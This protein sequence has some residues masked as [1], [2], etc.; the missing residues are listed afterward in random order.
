MTTVVFASFLSSVGIFSKSRYCQIN[1]CIKTITSGLYDEAYILD[2]Y[3]SVLSS[4]TVRLLQPSL[5]ID[6][7]T[8]LHPDI[9]FKSEWHKINF[10][11]WRASLL[12]DILHHLPYGSLLFYH[13]AD[14]CSYPQYLKNF[15]LGKRAVR[16]LAQSSD[17]V[18]FSL[19][20]KPLRTDCKKLLIDKYLF[21]NEPG[22]LS[23]VWASPMI[24]RNTYSTISFLHYINTLCLHGEH[25]P[26]PDTPVQERSP[27]FHWHSCEQS[28]LSVILHTNLASHGIDAS[29]KVS[30]APNRII[31]ATSR[32]LSNLIFWISLNFRLFYHMQAKPLCLKFISCF[33]RTSSCR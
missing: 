29:I 1:K 32:V 19:G 30:P 3:S 11:G 14:F 17:I 21:G 4:R 2:S 27:D 6:V 8:N 13:D 24:L 33:N 7:I 16:S 15:T 22:K 18:I 31:I 10:F 12:L 26:Y 9:N 25:L 23:G 20:Y 28:L 5:P